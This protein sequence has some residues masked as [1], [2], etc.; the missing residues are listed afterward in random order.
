MFSKHAK[1]G[2]S[3]AQAP[4]SPPPPTSRSTKRKPEE[5]DYT[6]DAGGHLLGT[7]PFIIVVSFLFCRSLEFIALSFI[8]P[9]FTEYVRPSAPQNK[10]RGTMDDDEF[11]A[12][13]LV[14]G[15]G[16]LIPTSWLLPR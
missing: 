10:V 16:H 4:L 5:E 13:N 2:L 15:V 12:G 1:I 3:A 14:K 8:F 7:L 11:A 6:T 9:L